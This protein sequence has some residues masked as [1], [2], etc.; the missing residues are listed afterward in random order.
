MAC[1][2][3]GRPAPAGPSARRRP[4]RS[5]SC[6]GCP[7]AGCAPPARPRSPGPPRRCLRPPPGPRPAAALGP[8]PTGGRPARSTTTTTWAAPRG[9]TPTTAA[10][11]TPGNG[12]DPT[13]D[14]H[15]G[16]RPL[17]GD[18]HVDEP[19]LDPQAPIGVEVPDVAGAVP[20][21]GGRGGP[22]GHPE[23]V[24]ARLDVGRPDAHLAGHLRVGGP[25]VARD[26]V[27][28]P[29][30]PA[31]PARRAR[32]VPRT[33]RCRD[34]R[35]PGR[36]GRC[37]RRAGPRSSRTGRA[38]R[39]PAAAAASHAASRRAREPRWTAAAALAT[40]PRAPRDR[41]RR[42]SPRR[43]PGPP[44]RRTPW[45]RRWPRPRRPCAWP[46]GSAGR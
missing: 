27:A 39:R 36:R 11:R 37:P 18:D 6:A 21:R 43:S 14:P 9:P 15:R 34:R 35:H 25:L 31:R 16:D 8:G 30:A 28:R 23:A 1:P 46:S 19:A 38:P 26:A 17:G 44:G 10:R 40:G 29:A 4:G 45:S 32:A 7:R 20:A 24:V 42:R 5:S 33:R 12:L 22:V 3:G 2:A 13:F 41:R